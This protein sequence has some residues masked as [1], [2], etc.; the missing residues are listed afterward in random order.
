MGVGKSTTVQFR[1]GPWEVRA[2][3]LLD[4]VRHE[5]G[6][7]ELGEVMLEDTSPM[8]SFPDYPGKRNYS[9]SFYSAV[10]GGHVVFES[11]FERSVLMVLEYDT[12]VV[13]V[14]AQPVGIRWP[15]EQRRPRVPD[16]FLRYRSGEGV[17]V[18]ARPAELIDDRARRSFE[19]TAQVCAQAGLGYRVVSD[20][21]VALRR[22][23]MFLA[24]FRDDA[25]AVG[26]RDPLTGWEG[27]LSQ[28]AALLSVGDRASGFGAAYR[29]LWAGQALTDLRQVLTGSSVVRVVA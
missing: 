7:G 13:A 19:A 25:F 4:G 3:Y 5:C 17:L 9:G 10:T 24:N 11:L 14:A 6:V 22:N 29:M 2:Q 23:L 21:P 27:T 1:T 20:L 8:R 18:D 26:D 12:D 16:F 15:G 28:L